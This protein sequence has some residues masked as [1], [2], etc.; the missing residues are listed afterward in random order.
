[1]SVD[2]LVDSTQLNTDLASVA[3]AIRAKS[4]SGSQ[5]AFPSGFVSEIGNIPSGGGSGLDYPYITGHETV[6]IG[7]N[8][9]T[10][11]DAARTY[12][13]S[14]H[15]SNDWFFVA[16]KDTPSVHNQVVALPIYGQGTCLRYRNGSIGTAAIA[17]QYDGKLIE[18]T[19]YELY[20]WG[21]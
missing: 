20:Y 12:F 21:N 7:A 11:T 3:D 10:N 13:N 16:L 8:S 18:G 15:S 14:L 9:V 17:G 6:T 5:L 1:M 2:K 4:G 19:Q